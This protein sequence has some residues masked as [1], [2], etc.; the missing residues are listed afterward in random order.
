[1]RDRELSSIDP[2]APSAEGAP[3]D[4]SQLRIDTWNQLKALA[5]Q[6]FEATRRGADASDLRA[7]LFQLTRPTR[8]SKGVLIDPS[9]LRGRA[10]QALSLLQPVEGYW[11]FPGKAAVDEL[12]QLLES[13]GYQKL[14]ERTAHLERAL[15]TGAYRGRAGATSSEDVRS[16]NEA[17]GGETRPYFEVLLVEHLSRGEEASVRQA[18][19]ELRSAS[20]PFTY[21]VVVVPSFEDAIIACLFNEHI[22]ACLIRSH[23]PFRS[24]ID[25]ELLRRYLTAVDR[26]LM[27]DPGGAESSLQLARAIKS[28][29]PEL[30]LY[31]VTD[32]PVEEVAG[33]LRQS[34]RRVFYGQED[35]R[36]LHLSLL[37]GIGARYETPF[38][39]S[40]RNYSQRPTGGFH[41]LPISRGKSVTK[42]HWIRDL[43][44]FY[45]ANLFL[46]E[47]SSTGGGL[48]SLLQPQG[49]LKKA[50]ELAA[51]AFGA[52]RTFFV[53]NG[54][55]TAN[56]IV[57][58]ALVAP[59][60]IVLVARDCH[61][62]HHYAL[63]LVGAQPLYLD[64]YPLSDYSMYGAVPLATIK[65][66]LLE[67]RRAGKLD[68]VRMLL[69][70]NC[71][72]DGITYNPLQ[73]MHEVLAIKPDMIFL[74]DEAWFAYA[75]FLP[76]LRPRTAM[77]AARVLRER[78]G[79]EEYR[80]QYEE[81]RRISP[82]QEARESDEVF[83]NGSAMPDPDQVRVRVY[84]TQSTHKTLTALRQGSMI[85]LHD[86][87]F[88]EDVAEPFHEA[89]MTH[90][91]TSPNYQ[92]LA[93][94][95]VGRRQT[96]LEGYELVQRSLQLAMSIRQRLSS[97][98]LLRKYFTVLVPEDMVPAGHRPSGIRTFQDPQWGGGGG[99]ERAWRTDEFVLDP[100]RITLHIGRTG[101]D[102]DTLRRRLMEQFDIQINKTS[103]N[104]LLFMIHIGMTRG[105]VAY[106]IE[107]LTRIAEELDQTIEEQNQL[108][109]ALHEKSVL[110][111]TRDLPP[112]PNFSRFHRCFAAA[113]TAEGDTRKAFFLA[114]RSSACEFFRLNGP[115]EQELS[116]GRELVSASF[117][118]PYPPGTPLLMPGQVISGEILSYLKALDVREIHGY[119]PRHGLRVFSQAALDNLEHARLQDGESV[120]EV[121][122]E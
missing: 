28:V 74:W 97:H 62:S 115:I 72:F 31:W 44:Q 32:T 122:T 83:L 63:L 10:R 55:S 84:A 6:L 103:R 3:Y 48:D 102:G 7:N 98:P 12:L 34:F 101:L 61:K 9:D 118:T 77:E 19:L 68:R 78:Y 107:V 70:T 22:Q 14:A 91:S 71:T 117:V 114:Y 26:G 65:R 110:S 36:E 42:S 38:F 30:D 82:A 47:T 39:T 49:P 104:T 58:Q 94:L 100:T 56:K 116:S 21:D 69:L 45:G 109:S 24:S 33:H 120:R 76:M 93:S 27:R 96:E 1:M 43:E 2:G 46:A 37:K 50:Q 89:Y 95:D 54:T 8:L 119:D 23:F 108:E 4:A 121:A 87:D 64:A 20:D 112:L 90:T 85:H 75:R 111:L 92:I 66:H 18:L 105:T 16:G 59:D 52:R 15:T 11:A 41:A 29:R 57:V 81:W 88:E 73:V 60:D 51:R 5:A 25:Q 13:E 113:D 17:A 86:Q 40:L 99:L 79:S 106:L 53:T 67:L 35:Y 80:R